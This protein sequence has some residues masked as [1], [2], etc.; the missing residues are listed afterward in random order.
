MDGDQFGEVRVYP[1]QTVS[2]VSVNGMTVTHLAAAGDPTTIQTAM[3]SATALD[4]NGHG[5]CHDLTTHM[6]VE[7]FTKFVDEAMDSDN[8]YELLTG[9]VDHYSEKAFSIFWNYQC[10][11][12]LECSGDDNPGMS[13][14]QAY[15][16]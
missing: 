4:N 12:S 15:K 13:G 11:A 16:A 10:L 3:P 7:A 2:S 5:L 1:S 9:R 14:L 6:C 8:Q